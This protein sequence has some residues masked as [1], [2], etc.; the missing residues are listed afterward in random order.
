VHPSVRELAFRLIETRS[1]ARCEA[2]KL[3]DRNYEAD[4]HRVVLSWFAAEEDREVL[5]CFELDL[6]TFWTAWWNGCLK[7]MH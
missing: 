3:I 5:H 4:D 6:K 7:L 1:L 2:I